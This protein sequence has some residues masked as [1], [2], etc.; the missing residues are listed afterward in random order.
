MSKKSQSSSA[1][2]ESIFN[3]QTPLEIEF[4]NYHSARPHV[5]AAFQSVCEERLAAGETTFGAKAA[6]ELVRKY[7]THQGK[8]IQIGAAY[9]SYYA[10]YLA[11]TDP[12]FANFFKFSSTRPSRTAEFA[13]YAELLAYAQFAED[14]ARLIALNNAYHSVEGRGKPEARDKEQALAKAHYEF[15]LANFPEVVAKHPLPTEEEV[16]E[17]N[18]GIVE[19]WQVDAYEIWVYNE[20]FDEALYEHGTQLRHLALRLAGGTILT[21]EA[22]DEES[23]D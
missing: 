10:R 12:R 9:I 3:P 5:F 18:Q 11:A 2:A 8:P 15:A 14:N 19:H 6:A 20:G 4:Y 7:R 22:N 23:E 21:E 13:G 16:A 1:N 17:R